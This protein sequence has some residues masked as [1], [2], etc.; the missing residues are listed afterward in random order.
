VLALVV[1][2]VLASGPGGGA[3]EPTA[4]PTEAAALPSE[5]PSEAPTSTESEPEPEA[6][7]YQGPQYEIVVV[8]EN[9]SAAELTRFWVLT[10]PFDYSTD[11]Y[12]NQVRMIVEDIAH[13]NGTAALMVDVVTDRE[14][15][16]AEASSTYE[17][18]VEEHGMDYVL[19]TIAAKE[20][21]HWAASYTGGFDYNTGEPSE[22][23]E[24]FEVLW[25]PH[26]AEELEQWRPALAG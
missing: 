23:A 5:L 7:V 10:S 22:S 8:D 3:S 24:A 19:E 13:Q 6:Y 11:E 26:A 16:E 21:S 1:A 17:D 14:V 18:F 2:V 25:R 9:V 20:Q 15:A 12:K 4:A